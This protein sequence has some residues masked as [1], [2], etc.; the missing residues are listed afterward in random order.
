MRRTRTQ[1][2]ASSSGECANGTAVSASASTIAA[3]CERPRLLSARFIYSDDRPDRRVLKP[4]RSRLDARWCSGAFEPVP[5]CRGRG[6]GAI[7]CRLAHEIAQKAI[8][9]GDHVVLVDR[10]EVALPGRQE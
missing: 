7:A 3:S 8:T 4:W 5:D 6:A 1:R 2:S 10:L 9:L